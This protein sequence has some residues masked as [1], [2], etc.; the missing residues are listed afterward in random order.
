[1]VVEANKEDTEELEGRYGRVD[2]EDAIEGVSPVLVLGI[3]REGVLEGSG[4]SNG[5]ALFVIEF[6][7]L[8]LAR[9][10]TALV[11]HSTMQ[12]EGDARN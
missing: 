5:E 4:D 3:L 8:P 1:M 9:S 6:I 12:V 7:Y 2:I 11:V 10:S